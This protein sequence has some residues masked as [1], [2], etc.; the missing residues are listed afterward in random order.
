MER[1]R[2][3]VTLDRPTDIAIILEK[4]LANNNQFLC[5]N[6][7]LFAGRVRQYENWSDAFELIPIIVRTRRGGPYFQGRWSCLS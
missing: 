7:E 1:T 6:I 5:Q 2:T 3:Q 4:A